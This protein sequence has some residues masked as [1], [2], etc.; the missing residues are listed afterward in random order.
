MTDLQLAIKLRVDDR[1][2]VG[3]LQLDE[4]QIRK[5]GEAVRGVAPATTGAAQGTE[6][7]ATAT[8][9][10]AAQTQRLTGLQR[11]EMELMAREQALAGN[12]YRAYSLM[13]RAIGLAGDELQKFIALKERE[14]RV[15]A[16]EARQR[17]RLRGASLAGLATGTVAGAS[18]FSIGRGAFDATVTLDRQNRA[19]TAITGSAQQ[20]GV[21][22]DRLR[23]LAERL[24]QRSGPLAD[25]WVG[26]A[27]A[28]KG[29]AAEGATAQAIFAGVVAQMARLGADSSRTSGVL[30]QLSQ[31]LGKTG[32]QLEDLNVIAENGLPIIQLLA[33]AYG[34]TTAE[35]R[36]LI[37]KGLLPAGEA[38]KKVFASMDDGGRIQGMQADISRLQESW[39]GLLRTI[40][41]TGQFRSVI[42]F[43]EE[44]NTRWRQMIALRS[45]I[46]PGEI[47]NSNTSRGLLAGVNEHLQDLVKKRQALDVPSEH[48]LNP[49]SD[50][51][52]QRQAKRFDDQIAE[53]LREREML[54]KAIA[55]FEQKANPTLPATSTAQALDKRLTRAYAKT[56]DISAGDK[57]IFKA[58]IIEKANAAGVDPSLALAIVENESAFN[59]GA[60]GLDAQGRPQGRGLFQTVPST[61]KAFGPQ[62][63]NFFVPEDNITAGIN[64]LADLQRRNGP[65]PYEMLK[66][67]RGLGSPGVTQ[68]V[69]DA[70]FRKVAG[71]A[72]KFGTQFD[73]SGI[74]AAEAAAKAEEKNAAERVS[75]VEDAYQKIVKDEQDLATERQQI[76]DRAYAT[77]KQGEAELARTRADIEQAAFERSQ[78]AQKE[79]LARAYNERRISADDYYSHLAALD[80]E[81]EQRTLARI[82]A[83]LTAER[84]KL[85]ELTAGSE[86]YYQTLQKIERATAQRDQ[87]V[88]EGNARRVNGPAADARGPQIG[89][90]VKTYAP[91]VAGDIAKFG[92]DLNQRL[93]DMSQIGFTTAQNL[94]NAFANFFS[95]GISGTTSLGAAFKT[96][97]QQ[98]VGQ[99]VAMM[100]MKAIS[101]FISLLG[102]SIGGAAEST[103][104]GFTKNGV[105]TSPNPM[106]VS[107]AVGGAVGVFSGP[108]TGTS[109]SIPAL[110]PHGSF[111]LRANAVRALA[112]YADGGPIAG[113]VAVKVSNGEGYVPP[114]TARRLGLARL[115]AMNHADTLVAPLLDMARG[116]L[117]RVAAFAEGGAVGGA[118]TMQTAALSVSQRT[119]NTTINIP[120]DASGTPAGSNGSRRDEL[121]RDV[122][123]VV[124]QEIMRHKTTPGG[125]LY[126]RG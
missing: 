110:L 109:D 85:R 121:A 2:L 29:S 62:G 47:D 108:G 11:V 51:E 50:R 120:I 104:V 24:G 61:F 4:Q 56:D 96:M 58:R 19:L 100:A 53:L 97:V 105:I 28:V 74:D 34:T 70:Y 67:Y 64:Y 37:G 17:E 106:P 83:E 95:T 26:F 27:T 111:V 39:D 33:Q 1:D 35:I 88:Q 99:I 13:G 79:S 125:A 91:G 14:A 12:S 102:G 81:A 86:E 63:G 45:E 55:D 65:N 21:E 124:E 48:A 77:V 8:A 76:I 112:G 30:Y 46:K 25:A 93:G 89:D 117:D 82:D 73:T 114:S 103:V 32:L 15:T 80:D 23:D 87:V 18:L 90:E 49:L 7:L 78:T 43:L 31:A 115:E 94:Q 126:P 3:R 84:A 59:P 119:D 123:R 9:N 71:S 69:Y 42:G 66:E 68:S 10:A 113:R 72:Q 101:G 20:A 92:D 36:D 116:N 60:V 40:G 16:D 5:F 98:M 57:E 41:E 52:T 54:E 122:R 118:A 22:L 38:L 44:I 107:R 6:R 75:I